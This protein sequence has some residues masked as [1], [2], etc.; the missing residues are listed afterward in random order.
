MADGREHRKW[1]NL[2]AALGFL[3]PNILGV[4]AFT[5]LPVAFSV[6]LAF[7]NWDLRRHNMF[8]NE[9][10]AFV[11][12]ENFVRLIFG[13]YENLGRFVQWVTFQELAEPDAP[14]FA[15]DFLPYLGNTLFLMLAMPFAVGGSLLAAMLLSKDTRGGGGWVHAW[16]LASVAL[17]VSAT[18]L[19]I[20]GLGATAMVILLA[21]VACGVLMLGAG[22]GTTVYRTLFYTPHFVQGVATFIL[23]KKLYNPSTG[24]INT[25][26]RPAL[27]SFSAVVSATPAPLVRS[28]LAVCLALVM[29]LL[30]WGLKRLRQTWVDGELGGRAAVLPVLAL[31]LPTALAQLWPYTSWCATA[32]WVVAGVLLAWHGTW[33]V[34]RGR[35]FAPPRRAEGFG[36][37]LMLSLALMVGQF[38]LLGLAPV[39]WHLPEMVAGVGSR[40]A[41]GLAPPAWIYDYHW[42]KPALMLMMLWAAIGSNNMLLYLAALTNVPQ[43]LYEAADIDGAG[44][45][46]RFWHVTWPQLAP[47]TFF[48]AVMSTIGGLQGGFEMARVMTEGGP[49]G[50]T[51]TLSYFIYQE[52]FQTGRLSFSAAI[53]WVLFLLVFGLTLFNW[54]FGNQYVN[55]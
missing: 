25:A 50:A 7:T 44:R 33:M 6:V 37:A 43:Q 19:T 29:G 26:L 27:D 14:I 12:F 36:S 35:D 21:G 3:L 32:L 23:W 52:G 55:E 48:I 16:L 24:P 31:L 30:A 46:Q 54:K 53:A 2:P 5:V 15:G 4:L 18:M 47:T 9:P 28:G 10:L 11:G 17:V 13:N 49:A 20:V 22:G 45:F 8:R 42:A 1:R 39:L 38:V 41:P 51:T 40:D 34:R